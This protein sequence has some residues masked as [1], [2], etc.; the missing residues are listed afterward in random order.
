MNCTTLGEAIMRIAPFEKLV[1]DMGTTQVQAQND[2]IHF[3]L[4]LR[5][6]QCAG[7]R[8]NGG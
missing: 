8:T 2:E 1:G 4:A 5:L 7:A 3:A 6:P